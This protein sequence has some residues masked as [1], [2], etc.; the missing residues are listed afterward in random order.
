MEAIIEITDKFGRRRLARKGE[1]PAD[2]ETIHFN[3][4]LMDAMARVMMTD[5]TEPD[6]TIRDGYGSAAGHRPGYA[7]APPDVRLR[8]DAIQAYEERCERLQ[9]AWR[10][11]DQ[12]HSAEPELMAGGQID[13]PR[14]TDASGRTPEATQLTTDAEQAWQDKKQRLEQAWRRHRA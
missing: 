12:P 2:G 10:H 6:P 1:V 4:T 7:F 13:L 5:S 11:R 14:R 9:D 8:Q 3:A